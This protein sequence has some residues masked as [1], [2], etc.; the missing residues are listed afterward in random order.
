MFCSEY[1]L[2]FYHSFPLAEMNCNSKT[3]LPKQ[4]IQYPAVLL[5]LCRF[6]FT[7]SRSDK[8]YP[9]FQRILGTTWQWSR[10]PQKSSGANL[11]LRER[12]RSSRDWQSENII[13]LCLYRGDFAKCIQ[14]FDFFQMCHQKLTHSLSLSSC[15]AKKKG[16]RLGFCPRRDTMFLVMPL[17]VKSGELTLDTDLSLTQRGGRTIWTEISS[18]CNHEPTSPWLQTQ[19]R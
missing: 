2:F 14:M 5:L 16:A 10:Y 9:S 19:G 15:P 18:N 8:F 13:G 3:K 12:V 1:S 6:L 7:T 17:P 4:Q 11:K